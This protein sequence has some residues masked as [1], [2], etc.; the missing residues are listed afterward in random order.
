MDVEIIQSSEN[1]HSDIR[2][3]TGVDLLSQQIWCWGRD[4]LR[5]EG[6][7][8][9]DLGF[10]IIPAPQY[11]ERVKNIYLFHI[12]DSRRVILRGFGVFYTDD[13]YGSIFVPRYE[14]IPKYTPV[15]EFKTLP[16]GVDDVTEFI[17]PVGVEREYC[18]IMLR[19]LIDWIIA[20]EEDTLAILGM[21]YRMAILDLWDNGKRRV[22][23]PQ[24]SI[25]EWTKLRDE[26][27]EILV[28]EDL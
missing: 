6:N 5:V 12:T 11:M 16:W 19:E 7:W 10:E 1:S 24:N 21:D 18:S 8:L 14:F 28:V 3:K 25:K 4:I 15:N 27:E 26:I 17:S 2:V 22:F 13:R 9:F 20:Y 23:S